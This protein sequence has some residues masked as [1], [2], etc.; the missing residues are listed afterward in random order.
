M[1]HITFLLIMITGIFFFS[2]CEKEETDPK[3]DMGQ[4]VKPAITSPGDGDDYVLLEEN[5]AD[6]MNFTW[7]AAKYVPENVA[8]PSY[9]LQMA[10]ADSAFDTGKQ[11]ISTTETTY[12][13]TVGSFNAVLLQLGYDP[14]VPV[15]MKFKLSSLLKSYD[16]GKVIPGTLLE[17]DVVTAAFTPYE[18]ATP[19][20]TGP[21]SLW[22]P[23]DYQGWNPAAAP[24]VFSPDHDG[25]YAGY[26]YFPPGGTFEFKFTTAPDWAHTNF[27]NAGEG[28]LDT[29]PGA[30]NLLVPGEGTYYLMIDTLALTWTY[31]LRN[32]ALIGSF[33][34]WAADEP[35]TWD[36]AHWAWTITKDFDAGTEFKWRANA[37]WTYNFGDNEGDGL[38]EQDGA[39][40]ILENTGNYTINLYLYE[41]TPRYEIIQNK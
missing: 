32:F 20:P 7:L 35:L 28:T 15:S 26:I 30:G 9:F 12:T 5:A 25:K 22:V 13:T 18:P 29:D 3:L 24:N 23:G 11:I 27:G 38:L 40:I 39:N 10:Q 31:E 16:D 41:P 14:G 6:E 1:K 33:N 37:D 19:P 34:E 4:A 17:S 2:S 8:N 21:D 36:D